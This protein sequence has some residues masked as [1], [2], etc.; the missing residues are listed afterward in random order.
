MP[1]GLIQNEEP[2]VVSL[3]EDLVKVNIKGNCLIIV[4]IPMSGNPTC[5]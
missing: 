4:T 5:R 2:E 3:V 1:E